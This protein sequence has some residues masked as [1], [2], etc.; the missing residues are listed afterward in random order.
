MHTLQQL[1]P[2]YERLF[3]SCEVK[4]AKF[5]EI[6]R[7]ACQILSQKDRYEAIGRP[8]QIPWYFIGITHCMECS[9]N[10]NR[11]L[12]NG[13]PLTARTVQVPKGRP[14]TGQ[15]P[16]TFEES[17]RDALQLMG[18]DKITDWS[19]AGTLY[20]FEQ[21]NGFGYRRRAI[22][23]PSP[24]LWSY[25][26]HYQKGKYASDGKYDPMLV[27]KQCGTATILRRLAEKQAINFNDQQLNRI[28]AIKELGEQVPFAP[29]TVNENALRLQVLLNEMGLP[30]LR[31]G[32]A[33]TNT[34]NA[35]KQV[36]GKYLKGD[37][38]RP[39]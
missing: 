20:L 29:N 31:D 10:F 25:S 38:R 7:I 24:Y 27:S 23:I 17:A 36:S 35:Y 11:H 13:D 28:K 26:N 6:D 1:K 16:F 33:G 3:N 15:P 2:E 37:S 32:K 22:N 39:L 18:Y 19:I 30:L 21:Y 34:S 5:S 12:H 8:L 14:K 4:P 9:L